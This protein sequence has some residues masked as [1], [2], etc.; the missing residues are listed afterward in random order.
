MDS[1]RLECDLYLRYQDYHIMHIDGT[2][3]LPYPRN[4]T[5][6]EWEREA[7]QMV[8]RDRERHPD[9]WAW[10]EFWKDTTFFFRNS[11]S[12]LI[13]EEH[14]RRVALA[15]ELEKEGKLRIRIEKEAV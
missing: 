7:R 10:I 14:M 3:Y 6:D 8:V 12:I 1:P 15:K 11:T 4:N 13:L 9:K 2:F 5:K